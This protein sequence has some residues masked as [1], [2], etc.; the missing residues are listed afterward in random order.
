MYKRQPL[1]N[2]FHSLAIEAITA[3]VGEADQAN[4]SRETIRGSGPNELR[5]T[6]NCIVKTTYRHPIDGLDFDFSKFRMHLESL[7]RVRTVRYNESAENDCLFVC[8]CGTVRHEITL[9]IK[10]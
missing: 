1:T 2:E 8:V 5:S 10:S 9:A 6:V 7:S 3:S 4:F